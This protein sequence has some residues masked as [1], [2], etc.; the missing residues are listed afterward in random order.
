MRK[1][2]QQDYCGF[3][4]KVGLAYPRTYNLGLVTVELKM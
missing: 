4:F 3:G 1:Y 2:K